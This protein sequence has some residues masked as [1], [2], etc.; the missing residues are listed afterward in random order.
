MTLQDNGFLELGGARLEYRHTGPQPDAAPTLVLLHEGLGSAGLWGDF[1]DKL[2]A[3]TG[4]G[5]FA[6]SR[7]GYGRSS[8]VPL[9]RPLTYMQDEAE[10]LASV[11]DAIGLRRGLLVGH[12]DGASIATL[13]FGAHQDHRVRGVSMIAPHFVVE[14]MTVAA[15]SEAKSAYETGDLKGKLARWHDDVETAFRGWNDAWLDPISGA[16]TSRMRSATSASRTDR[17]R[18][19]RPVWQ[20]SPDHDRRRGMLL[21]G[22]RHA[23]AGCGSCATSRGRGRDARRRGGVREPHPHHSRRAR[24]AAGRV[25]SPW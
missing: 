6:Y 3:A 16:G 22:R 2:A 1:P 10:T 7:V 12:S 5:V 21:P 8:P 15:I 9:P 24:D 4:A 18:R 17:S 13:Y 25:G 11:M 19:G 20:R 23:A 14:D